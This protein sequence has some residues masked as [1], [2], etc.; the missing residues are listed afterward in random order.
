MSADVDKSRLRPQNARGLGDR[1]REVVDVSVCPDGDPSVE[2]YVLERQRVGRRLQH[3][4]PAGPRHLEQ[5]AGDVDADHVPTELRD[6]RRRN[7]G[8]AAEVEAAALTGAEQPAER[9]DL[10]VTESR[11]ELLVPLR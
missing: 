2:G 5:V 8:A 9:P 11:P 7:P 6:R 3:L 10:L 4:Q 1:G